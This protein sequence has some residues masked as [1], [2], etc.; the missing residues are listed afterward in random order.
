MWEILGGKIFAV[1]MAKKKVTAIYTHKIRFFG[2][3]YLRWLENSAT[4]I[5]KATKISLIF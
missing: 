1:I 3:F 4:E 2:K 5:V